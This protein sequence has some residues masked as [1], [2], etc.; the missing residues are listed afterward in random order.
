MHPATTGETTG[1]KSHRRFDR[2]HVPLSYNNDER[3]ARLDGD[4]N[5]EFLPIKEAYRDGCNA[6]VL[7]P[8]TF[9]QSFHD[10]YK[11]KSVRSASNEHRALPV[12][13]SEV[14]SD[15]PNTKDGF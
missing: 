5:G 1:E 15:T 2:A 10:D 3:L 14:P 12:L 11:V 8:N 13:S 4:N 7:S 9:D 6:R